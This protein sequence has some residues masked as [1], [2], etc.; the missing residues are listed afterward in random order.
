MRTLHPFHEPQSRAGVSPDPAKRGRQ[1]RRLPYFRASR[2]AFSLFCLGCFSYHAGFE[3]LA[4]GQEPA[5]TAVAQALP[6]SVDLRPAFD[7]WGLARRTQGKRGT[8]SVF[9]VTGALEYA[10]AIKLRHAER[11]SVEFLNWGANKVIGEYEDGGFFSDLWKAFDV[12]GICLEQTLP[13]RAEFDKALAPGPEV[14]AEAKTRLTLGLRH[15]WIKE[16]DVKTGLTDE[17]LHAIKRTLS[18]GWPVCGG[19]RWPKQ[20]KWSDDVLQMCPADAVFDGHSLLLVGYREET[21]QPEGGVFL[22]RNTNNGG[23]DGAMPYTYAQAYMNDAVWIDS[24]A[25]TPSATTAS[26]QTILRTWSIL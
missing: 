22:F 16:W 8:C 11:F 21:N 23:R 13:Y 15:H 3:E 19:F 7:K 14:L 24:D 18:Q 1:A 9:T 12:Y 26:F 6:A 20:P 10:A 25:P 5:P 4:T 17:H 2:L